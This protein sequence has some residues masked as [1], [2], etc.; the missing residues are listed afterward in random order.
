MRA[1][2][3]AAAAV[4]L[5]AGAATDARAQPFRWVDEQGN[6]HYVG[7]RD[8]VPEQYRPQ[9][10]AETPPE[11]AKSDLRLT[12]DVSRGGSGEC[13]L[14]IIGARGRSD[15]ARSYPNCVDCGRAIEALGGDERRRARCV[16]VGR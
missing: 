3:P 11:P 9:L 8:Q 1:C 13:V 15:V 4:L 5:L 2:L 6:V 7:T 12:P 16:A 10:P 14:R